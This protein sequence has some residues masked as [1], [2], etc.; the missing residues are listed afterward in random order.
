[1]KR[2]AILKASDVP[3][4][5]Q[6][7]VGDLGYFFQ[8]LLAETEDRW[9]I[10]EVFQD[11]FPP[12]LADYDGFVVTGSPASCNDAEPW[13]RRLENVVREV[14]EQ[15]RPLLGVCFGSQLLA[16]ALGGQVGNNPQG[17]DV[18]I[19]HLLLTQSGQEI[20][21]LDGAP[22]PLR[23]LETH[24][25][26]VTELPAKAVTLASSRRTPFE[27]YHLGKYS[28]GVQG[29]PELDNQA[30][31]DLLQRRLEAGAVSGSF[32]E[33]AMTNLRQ[34]RPHREFWQDWLRG[35]MREG[36]L[37]ARTAS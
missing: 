18:G 31:L 11:A 15:Q 3:L 32:A 2:Y 7:R 5:S 13:I 27:I 4:T 28:L 12:R 14:H 25:E 22:S 30:V 37:Q 24:Q 8:Q 6:Q 26:I 9:D 35:F 29:H 33:E 20:A 19:A 17:W 10:W 1:M 21:P 36:L 34:D 16:R 23:V